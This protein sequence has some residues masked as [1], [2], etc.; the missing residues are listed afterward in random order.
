MKVEYL[1]INVSDL[2]LVAPLWD[3]LRKHQEALSP[4]FSQHYANR[5][6]KARRTELLE[7]GNDSLHIDLATDGDSKQII[8]YCVSVVAP[9]KKGTLESIFVEPDRRGY[10]I[11]DTLMLKALEWMK[12]K[13]AET[14][15][16][17][18]GVGNEAVIPF[19]NRY[20][21]YPRTIVLQQKN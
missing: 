4:H 20:G 14:F 2:D 9:D 15:V 3:K 13:K 7:A 12:G 6:W 1:E 16:L 10:G 8:G 11:G 21:F 18:V 5:T 17:D 19:Y